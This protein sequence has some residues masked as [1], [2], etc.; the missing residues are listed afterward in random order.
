M[1]NDSTPRN[2]PR[3]PFCGGTEGQMGYALDVAVERLLLH[4]RPHL[5]RLMDPRLTNAVQAVDRARRAPKQSN[6]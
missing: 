3:C 4:L 1:V 6:D 5:Q 2:E